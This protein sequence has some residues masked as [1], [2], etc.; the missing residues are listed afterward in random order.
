[1]EDRVKVLWVGE[2]REVQNLGVS[3]T[4]PQP[5]KQPSVS[6][7]TE[8]CAGG[9]DSFPICPRIAEYSS[10][11]EVE[12]NSPSLKHGMNLVTYF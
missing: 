4:W 3:F 8:P 6:K 10:L 9:C 5:S 11:Q 2:V 1:M 12:A 7:Q